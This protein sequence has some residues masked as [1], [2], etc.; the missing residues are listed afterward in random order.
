MRKLRFFL[1]FFIVLVA[2]TMLVREQMAGASANAFVNARLIDL[3]APIAGVLDMPRRSL[4]TRVSMGETLVGISDPLADTVRLH[5]LR[6]EQEQMMEERD[7][8]RARINALATEADAWAQKAHA[9]TQARARELRIRLDAANARVALLDDEDTVA[10]GVDAFAANRVREER[11]VLQAALGALDENISI[12]DAYTDAP[13]DDQ[14]ARERRAERARL[15]L[16]ANILDARIAAMES[17]LGIA[18]LQASRLS[19]AVVASPT[20]GMLWDVLQ[21]NGVM[22]QRGDP[23]IT[24]V[25]CESTMVTLSVTEGIYNTLRIGQSATFRLSGEGTLYPATVSRLAGSGAAGV[26]EN[27]AITPGPRHL[28]RYDVLL[29]VP[30]LRASEQASC[31]IGRTGRAFFEDRPFDAIRTWLRT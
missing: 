16:D 20:S 30:G 1:G 7:L 6:M 29:A 19:G 23:L 25:D 4:G 17:R 21:A 2:I 11:D 3:R 9:Y 31:L 22:V 24:L 15:V 28:E 12:G 26:Y 8:L 18:Q 27:M 14:V 5:D 13:H 10:E